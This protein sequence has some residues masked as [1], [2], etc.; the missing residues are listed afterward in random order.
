MLWDS[1]K[2]LPFKLKMASKFSMSWHRQVC[3]HIWYAKL[4]SRA[5]LKLK[6]SFYCPYLF[7]LVLRAFQMAWCNSWSLWTMLCSYKTL[8]RQCYKYTGKCL[9][10]FAKLWA[11]LLGSLSC[12][13]PMLPISSLF[14][15]PRS[16][17]PSGLLWV[18]STIRLVLSPD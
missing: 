18:G 13:C 15:K 11:F 7:I 2:H 17:S 5:R 12:F 3:T 9:S 10:H 16:E 6:T 1:R 8:L 4:I 14:C